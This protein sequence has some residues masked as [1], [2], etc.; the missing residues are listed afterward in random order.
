[1][2]FNCIYKSLEDVNSLMVHPLNPNKHPAKQI[3][4]LAKII[5]YQGQR[6]PVVVSRLSGRIIKG[7]GRLMAIKLLGWEKVAVD[8]QDYEDEAQEYADL[9]CDNAI[10]EWSELD[11]GNIHE[12]FT[13]FGPE[14]DIEYLGLKD[15]K[16][17]PLEKEEKEID[18]CFEYKIE[19]DCKNDEERISLASELKDRGYAVRAI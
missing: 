16:I 6:S 10:S 5:S 11:L 3:E 14:L 17:E 1:M 8:Y 15:F 13:E 7:H 4:R 9:V 2:K 19:I 12:I 18:L